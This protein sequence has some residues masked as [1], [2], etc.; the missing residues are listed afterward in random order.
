MSDSSALRL[1]LDI[2]R[3]VM[4]EDDLHLPHNLVVEQLRDA[5]DSCHALLTKEEIATLDSRRHWHPASQGQV[6]CSVNGC[7]YWFNPGDACPDHG[8]SQDE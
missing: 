2:E 3:I 1:Y 4:R 5:L 8:R 6:R 7:H